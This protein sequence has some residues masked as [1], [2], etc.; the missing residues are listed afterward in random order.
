MLPHHAV[1][2]G[3]KS[4]FTDAEVYVATSNK[5]DSKSPFNFGKRNNND[6]CKNSWRN[7][8]L[9]ANPYLADSYMKGD[10]ETQ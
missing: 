7:I 10:Q 2:N 9:A 8:I 5:V 1:Y 6:V 3:L 4:Q